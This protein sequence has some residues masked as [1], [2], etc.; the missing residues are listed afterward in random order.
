MSSRGVADFRPVFFVSN[1]LLLGANTTVGWMFFN[2]SAVVLGNAIGGAIFMGTSEHLMNHWQ[3]RLPW[4]MGH[5]PGTL[6][7]GDVESTR[8]A[9]E[10]RTIDEKQQMKDLVRV[11]SRTLSRRGASMPPPVAHAATFSA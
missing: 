6:A 3:S 8:K 9:R 2:Q 10:D 4:E 5:A 1:G 11:R 7:A